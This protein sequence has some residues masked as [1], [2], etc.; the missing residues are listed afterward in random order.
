MLENQNFDIIDN[1]ANKTDVVKW[2]DGDPTIYVQGVGAETSD[3]VL[4][5][6]LERCTKEEITPAVCKK[7]AIPGVYLV[8]YSE[9][10]FGKV[11][12]WITQSECGTFL[13]PNSKVWHYIYDM[14]V[15]YNSGTHIHL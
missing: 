3:Y 12:L 14:I 11:S 7:Q 1:M 15:C 13:I 8:E 9:H 2:W 10:E 6:F 4:K 5:M